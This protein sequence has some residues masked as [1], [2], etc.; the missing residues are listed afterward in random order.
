MA[1]YDV[2][3][4]YYRGLLLADVPPFCPGPAILHLNDAQPSQ[5]REVTKEKQNQSEKMAESQSDLLH[6]PLFY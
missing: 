2:D 3:G 1:K 6:L 4:L 5:I